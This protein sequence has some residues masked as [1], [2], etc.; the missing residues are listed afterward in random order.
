MSGVMPTF[1]DELCCLALPGKQAWACS[2][3]SAQVADPPP[4][5]ACAVR[6]VRHAG[7]LSRGFSGSQPGCR[8][9]CPRSVQAIRHGACQELRGG[10]KWTKMRLATCNAWAKG[11]TPPLTKAAHAIRCLTLMEEA[12]KT[13]LCC[14][15][16]L[17]QERA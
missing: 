5:E 6:S 3:Q 13:R 17:H 8:L 2:W 4:D 1:D 7:L 11:S 14:I 12:F 10:G 9:P 16:G 15:R